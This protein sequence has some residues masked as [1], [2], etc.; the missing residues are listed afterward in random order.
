MYTDKLTVFCSPPE[1][2]T[3][4]ICGTHLALGDYGAKPAVVPRKKKKK[5]RI[6]NGVETPGSGVVTPAHGP[7]D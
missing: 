1:D 5:K 2:A 7:L 4:L 3:C 6:I